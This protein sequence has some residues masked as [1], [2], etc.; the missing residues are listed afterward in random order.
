MEDGFVRC[1]FGPDVL[2]EFV[3]SPVSSHEDAFMVGPESEDG[4]V[5][6]KHPRYGLEGPHDR[7]PGPGNEGNE[8][9]AK[10]ASLGD[11]GK[12]VISLP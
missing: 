1:E 11:T 3:C 12:L 10:G 5:V 6:R 9:H 8:H 7:C 2:E 4:E